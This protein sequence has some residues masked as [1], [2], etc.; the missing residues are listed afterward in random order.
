MKQSERRNPSLGLQLMLKKP[1]AARKPGSD[2]SE[3]LLK[4]RG[5]APG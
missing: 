3:T 1:F 2:D 5:L 4:K